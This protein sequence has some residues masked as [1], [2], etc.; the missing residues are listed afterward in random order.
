MLQKLP[1]SRSSQGVVLYFLSWE[2]VHI[3]LDFKT[4]I[5]RWLFS[6]RVPSISISLVQNVDRFYSRKNVTFSTSLVSENLNKSFST[7][8]H[9]SVS[10]SHQQSKSFPCAFQFQ[11]S[12]PSFPSSSFSFIPRGVQHVVRLRRSSRSELG[13]EYHLVMPVLYL[14][15]FSKPSIPYKKTRFFSR[16]FSLIP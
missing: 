5:S 11:T 16:L 4:Q 10:R 8:I 1:H 14:A 7:P 15:P 6:S 13:K 3:S 2:E 9:S 12:K